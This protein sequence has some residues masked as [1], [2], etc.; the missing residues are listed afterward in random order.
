M[1]RRKTS[2]TFVRS[3]SYLSRAKPTVNQ[4]PLEYQLVDL[5]GEGLNEEETDAIRTLLF[6]VARQRR[7]AEE[8]AEE[9]ELTRVVHDLERSMTRENR[10][11]NALMEIVS[12]E[13]RASE[14]AST[15][16]YGKPGFTKDND[17]ATPSP[18]NE[19]K[20]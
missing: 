20:G 19:L 1:G 17:S 16:L 9:S 14:I 11:L 3:L 5:L 2:E 10:Y 15:A 4:R 13:G 7:R 18:T 6:F 8:V 12:L